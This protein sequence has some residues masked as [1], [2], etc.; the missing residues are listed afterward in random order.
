MGMGASSLPCQSGGSSPTSRL[1]ASFANTTPPTPASP[2][3]SPAYKPTRRPHDI[4]TTSR[5]YL[6]RKPYTSSLLATPDSTT[7]TDTTPSDSFY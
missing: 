3:S 7:S 6:H 4:E 1:P 2:D 5:F